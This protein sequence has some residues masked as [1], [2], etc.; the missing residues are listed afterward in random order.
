VSTLPC[1][2]EDCDQLQVAKGVCQTHYY[3]LRRNG[4]ITSKVR[5]RADGTI[6]NGYRFLYRPSH[7]QAYANG[8][9]PEH[10]MVMADILGRTLLPGENPHHRNGDR[11]DNRPSNLELWTTHQPKGQRVADKVAWA[12][13]I[14]DM[15]GDLPPEVLG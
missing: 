6:S 10:R 1:T 13:E 3:Q 11:A 2:V 5:T 9:V 7:P 15:Y 4:E 8:Y 12:R 14:L